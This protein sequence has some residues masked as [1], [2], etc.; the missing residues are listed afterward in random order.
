MAFFSTV[1]EKLMLSEDVLNPSVTRAVVFSAD[2]VDFTT[3]Y[4]ECLTVGTLFEYV[5]AFNKRKHFNR[6]EYGR[7]CQ[8]ISACSDYLEELS[9]PINDEDECDKKPKAVRRPPSPEEKSV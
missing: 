9:E 1:A 4:P 7:V 3:D 8:A 5:E 6:A 2:L